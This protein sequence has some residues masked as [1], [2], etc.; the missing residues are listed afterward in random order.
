MKKCENCGNEHNGTY[1]SGRFCSEKC[2]RGFGT[3]ENKKEIYEK[4][5]KSLSKRKHNDVKKICPECKHEFTVP[6]VKRNQKCCSIKCGRSLLIKNPEYIKNCSLSSILANQQGKMKGTKR[7]IRGFYLFNNKKIRCD[8]KLEFACLN[9]FE[10]HYKVKN[11]E[12]CN[13]FIE[14]IF[15]GKIKRYLPDFLIETEEKIYITECKSYFKITED[16]KNSESW[17]MYYDT[18]EPKKIALKKYC[19]EHN[20][21]DIFFTKDMHRNFY[22]NCKH[23]MIK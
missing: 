6:W 8:S 4:V 9:Y 11:M 13:F 5:S 14:Y 19:N 3:K 20:Y 23:L 10:S 15:N 16:V 21:E 22:E 17:S 2:A 7:A 18:I 1:G 12:R